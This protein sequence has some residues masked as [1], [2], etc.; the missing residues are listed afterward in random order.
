MPPW[1]F[2]RWF[3]AQ[4]GKRPSKKELHV[5]RDEISDAAAKL[6]MLQSEHMLTAQWE[7]QRTSALYAWQIKDKDKK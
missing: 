2:D 7:A 1:D 6:S 3:E 4:H 5:L